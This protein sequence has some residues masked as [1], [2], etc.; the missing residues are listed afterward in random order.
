M[1]PNREQ[2]KMRVSSVSVVFDGQLFTNSGTGTYSVN[3]NGTGSL[4]VGS[5]HTPQLAF[6]LNSVAAGHPKALQFLDTNTGD[7]S[8][9]LV[10][11]GSMLKQ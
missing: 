4:S 9:N 8:G 10:I 3:S 6:A 5:K 1:R 2:V 7:G 11:T